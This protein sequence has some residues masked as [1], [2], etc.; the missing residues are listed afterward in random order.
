MYV[1]KCHTISVTWDTSEQ[2]WAVT[3][4]DITGTSLDTAEFYETKE[5]AVD[6]AQAYYD[7]DRCHHLI[8]QKRAA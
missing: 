8:I 5:D 1:D 7:S 2:L 4:H 3:W 6:M